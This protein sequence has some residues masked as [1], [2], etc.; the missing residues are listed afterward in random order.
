MASRLSLHNSFVD[1]LGSRDEEDTR[2]YYNS[3]D[4]KDM[5]YPCIRYSLSGI[6]RK[7]ANNAAYKNLNKYNVTLIDFDPESEIHEKI[8]AK[9]QYCSF[10]TNYKADNLQH[11]VYTIYY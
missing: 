10:D 5:N 2:A 1:I 3:P 4:K 7:H 8:L 11:F 9:F 6:D